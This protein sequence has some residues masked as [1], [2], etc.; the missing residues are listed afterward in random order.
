MNSL[1]IINEALYSDLTAGQVLIRDDLALHLCQ[2][3]SCIR[4]HFISIISGDD[5]APYAQSCNRV[6]HFKTQLL[7]VCLLPPFS[8]RFLPF[9]LSNICP[10]GADANGYSQS[11]TPL[12]WFVNNAISKIALSPPK[13]D[14]EARERMRD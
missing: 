8:S 4:L 11:R 7:H 3:V 12:N 5:G 13:N 10:T 14:G 1:Y 9:F 6:I 2:Q